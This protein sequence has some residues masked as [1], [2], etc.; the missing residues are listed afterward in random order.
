MTAI[1]LLASL[2]SAFGVKKFP[3]PKFQPHIEAMANHSTP[4]ARTEATNCYKAMYL[5]LGD[6]VTSFMDKLKPQFKDAVVKEFA[7]HKEKN[8]SHKRLTR[9]EKAKAKEA[10]LDAIIAEETKEEVVDVYEIAPASKILNTFTPEW[11]EN[12]MALKKWDE[13]RD[14]M[15]EVTNAA[16]VAKLESGNYGDLTQLVKKFLTDSNVVVS[17]NAIKAAGSLAQGLRQ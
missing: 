15:I 13:K 11:I 12:T 14:K 10:E 4:A 16:N 9:T 1:S 3:F 2:I 7:E 5:W 6:A 8:K 17:Q